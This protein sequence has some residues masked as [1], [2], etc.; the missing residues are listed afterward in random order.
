MDIY[1]KD[2]LKSEMIKKKMKSIDSDKISL[3]KSSSLDKY[4]TIIMDF[5]N[6]KINNLNKKVYMKSH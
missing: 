4:N 3:I 1:K 5:N 6:I 2:S